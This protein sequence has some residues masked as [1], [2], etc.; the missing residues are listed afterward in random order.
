MTTFNLPPTE[1]VT[2]NDL[3]IGDHVF[4]HGEVFELV[5]IYAG[6]VGVSRTDRDAD[7]VVGFRT[8]LVQTFWQ[9]MPRHWAQDWHIQGN[10]H[11]RWARVHS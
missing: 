6:S 7:D 8:R 4:T 11:A 3:R 10:A 1:T 5:S 9:E 2:T